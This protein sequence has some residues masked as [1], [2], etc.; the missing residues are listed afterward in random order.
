MFRMLQGIVSV[1]ALTFGAALVQAQESTTLDVQGLEQSVEML[2]AV[3]NAI[4]SAG[5]RSDSEEDGRNTPDWD[6][7]SCRFL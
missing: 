7:R 6:E 4:V 5:D 1:T 3:V 2:F